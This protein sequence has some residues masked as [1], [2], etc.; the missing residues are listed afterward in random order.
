MKRKCEKIGSIIWST[1]KM[2]ECSDQKSVD[3]FDVGGVIGIVL[4]H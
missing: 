4:H 2:W 1:E 3:K